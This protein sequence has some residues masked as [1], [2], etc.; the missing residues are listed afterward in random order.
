MRVRELP[1][2]LL[3]ASSE[4]EA[5]Y[6]FRSA[7]LAFLESFKSEGELPPVPVGKPAGFA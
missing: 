3:A 1:D 4:A 2:F 5:L 7:L 6:D